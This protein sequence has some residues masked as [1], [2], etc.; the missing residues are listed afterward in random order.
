VIERKEREK[1]RWRVKSK[2][3]RRKLFQNRNRS[4]IPKA[5]TGFTTMHGEA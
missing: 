2:Q 3:L 5:Q 1:S 4:G